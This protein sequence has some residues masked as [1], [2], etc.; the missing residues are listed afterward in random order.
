M[1]SYDIYDVI[2][3]DSELFKLYQTDAIFKNSIDIGI[4]EDWSNEKILLFALKSGY[5]AKRN[6]DDNYIKNMLHD[7]RPIKLETTNICPKCGESETLRYIN[8]SMSQL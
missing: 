2:D 3:R 4:E 5:K 6:I 7:R 8:N 1:K